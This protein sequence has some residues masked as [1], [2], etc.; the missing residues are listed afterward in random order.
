MF[1]LPY[2]ASIALNIQHCLVFPA[3]PDACMDE[4]DMSLDSDEDTTMQ[5]DGRAAEKKTAPPLQP[6]SEDILP[7][8]SDPHSTDPLPSCPVDYNVLKAAITQYKASKQAGTSTTEEEEN[9]ASFGVNPHQSYLYPN[10]AQW[11]PYSGSPGFHMSSAFSSPAC[12]TSQ[13]QEYSQVSS[14]S[15]PLANTAPLSQP[16]NQA[17]PN[18]SVNPSANCAPPGLSQTPG[19]KGDMGPDGLCCPQPLPQAL[20]QA[21]A[22]D[23]QPFLPGP[24]DAQT[25]AMELPMLSSSSSSS[26]PCTLPSYPEPPV[27]PCP[28]PTPPVPPVYNWAVPP[29]AQNSCAPG[30]SQAPF[31]KNEGAASAEGLCMG[32]GEGLTLNNKVDGSMSGTPPSSMQFQDRGIEKSC[33]SGNVMPCSQGSRTSVNSCTESHRGGMAP[34]RGMPGRG[35]AGNPR[36]LLPRPGGMMR[37]PCR[38]GPHGPNSHNGNRMFG[39][40]GPMPGPMDIRRGGFRGRGMPPMP[41]RSRPGRG[42]MWGGAHCNRGYGPPKDYY[43]DY[44]Y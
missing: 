32:T 41:M 11:S 7:P 1:L 23:S 27:F 28:I 12:P 18:S 35:M 43:S 39:P 8:H 42:S 33:M 37:P 9:L 19:S 5:A 3:E 13:G 10:S 24:Q 4:E 44:S 40:R 6:V 26:V 36:V 2:T 16:A 30:V 14:M 22:D 15:A 25:K 38:G 17:N 29:G 31:R 21:L 34:A 20:T